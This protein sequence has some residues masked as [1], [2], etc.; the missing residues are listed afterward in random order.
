MGPYDSPCEQFS[1]EYPTSRYVVG[2][3]APID[4]RIS[5]EEDD[6][7]LAGEE[8][9]ETSETDD[10]LPLVLGF[11][12]ASIGLSFVLDHSCTHIDVHVTWG[13]YRREGGSNEEETPNHNP[14][15]EELAVPNAEQ[16]SSISPKQSRSTA[17]PSSEILRQEAA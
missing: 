3:L 8:E 12:P 11:H 6:N 15:D 9:D 16:S 4:Q 13:D 7:L 17:C 14:Q 2:R 10:P 1:G 5:D